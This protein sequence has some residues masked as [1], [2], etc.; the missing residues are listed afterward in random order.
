[1]TKTADDSTI[2][3]GDAAA[4]TITVTNVGGGVTR[5]VLLFD[6]LPAGVVWDVD[7]ELCEIIPDAEEDP[8]DDN[9]GATLVCELGDLPPTDAGDEDEN[10]EPVVIHVSGKTTR[11]NCGTLENLVVVL[12]S[13]EVVPE[14]VDE[15]GQGERR[16]QGGEIP[17]V[18]LN[19]SESATIDVDCPSSPPPPPPPAVDIQIVKSASPS[20]V[21]IGENITWT[22]TVTNDGPSNATGV[23]VTDSLPAEVSFVSA[24]ASQGSG[25]S[26]N[27]VVTCALGNLNANASATITIVSTRSKRRPRPRSRAGRS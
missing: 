2:T 26:F 10:N 17:P 12:A 20:S 15:G 24:S 4:F 8:A 25:C 1:V 6:D 16:L 23:V 18:L 11:A 7:S 3:A 5:D 27:G 9:A 13:N 22:L 14:V 19:N 21:L